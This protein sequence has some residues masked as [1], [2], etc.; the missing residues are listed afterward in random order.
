MCK[1]HQDRQKISKVLHVIQVV[2]PKRATLSFWSLALCAVHGFCLDQSLE[3]RG[4]P[5]PQNNV[6]IES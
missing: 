4:D 1:G 3:V 2:D 5:L 6:K